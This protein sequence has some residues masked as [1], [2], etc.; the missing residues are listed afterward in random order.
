VIKHYVQ[1]NL[2]EKRVCLGLWLHPC[3]GRAAGRHGCYSS[4]LRAHILDHKHE[5]DR[6]NWKWNV[7][8]N[9]QSDILLPAK[10]SQTVLPTEDLVFKYMSLW[11]GGIL[12]QTATLIMRNFDYWADTQHSLCG[13]IYSLIRTARMAPITTFL[14]EVF[15]RL[16][17]AFLALWSS[18]KFPLRSLCLPREN[19]PF[20]SSRYPMLALL[21]SISIQLLFVCTPFYSGYLQILGKGGL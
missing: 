17:R 8:F 16:V 10:L 1:G 18:G 9:S 19:P 12:I 15:M 13:L 5:A 14:T 3:R 7:S 20:H 2:I 21:L 6:V 4:K 11:G